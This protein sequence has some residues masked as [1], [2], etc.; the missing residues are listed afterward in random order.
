M[1]DDLSLPLDY[2]F[3]EGIILS[4]VKTFSVGFFNIF[5]DVFEWSCFTLD[6]DVFIPAEEEECTL[7]LLD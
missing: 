6:F 5:T 1:R 4:G 7:F 3:P 2:S